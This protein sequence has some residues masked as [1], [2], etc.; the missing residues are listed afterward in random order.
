MGCAVAARAA[1]PGRLRTTAAP[2]ETARAEVSDLR[3]HGHA[4]KERRGS[5]C[6]RKLAQ[7]RQAPVFGVPDPAVAGVPRQRFAAETRTEVPDEES[8]LPHRRVSQARLPG[9]DLPADLG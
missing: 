3:L 1:D 6:V 5:A 4:G 9:S 7:R 2:G 8:A